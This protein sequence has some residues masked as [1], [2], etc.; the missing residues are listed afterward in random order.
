[1]KG[2]SPRNLKYMKAFAEAWPDFSFVQGVLAQL[3]WGHLACRGTKRRSPAAI[4]LLHGGVEVVLVD[5]EQAGARAQVDHFPDVGKMVL[6]GTVV[7][8]G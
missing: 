6:L 5:A 4:E 2:F 7:V 1:M 8:P 3:P